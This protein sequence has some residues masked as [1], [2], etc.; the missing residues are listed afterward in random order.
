MKVSIQSSYELETS[1]KSTINVIL[2]TEATK[3][4]SFSLKNKN[5]ILLPTS[6]DQ[7]DNGQLPLYGIHALRGTYSGTIFQMSLISVY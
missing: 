1:E 5:E 3:N 7:N 6:R 2:R 4:L